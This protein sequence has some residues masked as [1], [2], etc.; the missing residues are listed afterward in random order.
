MLLSWLLRRVSVVKSLSVLLFWL[1]GTSFVSLI[2]KENY[3]E[4]PDRS[5]D[6]FHLHNSK[7]GGAS[8]NHPVIVLR[9]PSLMVLWI[10]TYGR[11]PVYSDPI[12]CTHNSWAMVRSNTEF[13][14]LPGLPTR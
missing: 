4:T 13:K 7:E 1:P 14:A 2:G 10:L 5:E 12:V 11:P 8:Q 3:H 6:S 9:I